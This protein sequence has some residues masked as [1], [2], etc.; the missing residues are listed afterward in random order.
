LSRLS[1]EA[2]EQM[3]D[4]YPEP[5][6]L[7][8]F[9][10]S[11]ATKWSAFPLRINGE[12]L[13]LLTATPLSANTAS[14]ITFTTGKFVRTEVITTERLMS[15]IEQHFPPT[16]PS[17]ESIH[18][19]G[20]GYQHADDFVLTTNSSAEDTATSTVVSLVDAVINQAITMATSDI[21]FEPT[22]DQLEVRFRIDGVLQAMR[23]IASSEQLAVISRL[24][25]MARMD[26][27]ERRKPQDGRITMEKPDATIDIRVSSIPTPHG[28]KLVLR[29]LD[30]SAQIRTLASLGMSAKDLSLLVHYLDKPQGM[31]LVTGPT[32]SGKTTTLY[33]ALS[34]LLKPAVNIMT[35]EDPIEYEVN[36]VTQS[37]VKPEIKYDFATALRAFLRQDPDIIMVGEIR[38][39]ETAQI[40]LRAAMT[41]HLVLSTV[42]TNSAAATVVRLVDLGV[43]SYLV[44]S[45]LS[46]VVAQRLVRR[47]CPQC[48]MANS[49]PAEILPFL[50]MNASRSTDGICRR[51]PGCHQCSH[52][53]YRGRVGVFE[54]LEV[55]DSIRQ[56]IREN[57]NADTIKSLSSANGLP[58]LRDS[59]LA[60]VLNGTT[61]VEEMLRV[62]D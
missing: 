9:S 11:L 62:V 19:D 30:K 51:G 36:G 18:R 40:A 25:L 52:T 59:A 37:Q 3:T 7:S 29:L 33:A 60:L 2:E 43:E 50:E 55:T 42:H 24:K 4:Y 31:V 61:S 39:L 57:Q 56:A 16:A 26:I 38:D 10:R 54:M 17:V 14:E 1:P 47:L 49:S 34:H 28:E 6:A 21:H 15:L 41:G 8:L 44:S 23:P 48:K 53:G 5:E 45:S 27:A 12:T 22:S 32:G 13:T 20:E 46:L 35:I 58:T